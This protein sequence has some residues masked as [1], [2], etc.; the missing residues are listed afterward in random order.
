[1]SCCDRSA[2]REKPFLF[3]ARAHVTDCPSQAGA[4][5]SGSVKGERQVAPGALDGNRRHFCCFFVA[6]AKFGLGLYLPWQAYPPWLPDVISI[7]Q[8]GVLPWASF[9]FHLT[10]DTLG[11]GCILP[12]TRAD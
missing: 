5:Q 9:R 1:M 4:A 6:H 7:R 10:M 3:R 12:T 11:L 2:L 8:T